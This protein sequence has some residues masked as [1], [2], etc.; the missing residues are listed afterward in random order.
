MTT[1]IAVAAGLAALVL[2]ICYAIY[3]ANRDPVFPGREREV[4]LVG[5]LEA[6]AMLKSG[7]GWTLAPEED[8]NSVRGEVYLQRWVEKAAP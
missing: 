6:D 8:F 1:A 7:E 3:R 5:Y 4:V 2:L